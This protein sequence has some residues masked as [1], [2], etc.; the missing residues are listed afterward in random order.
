MTRKGT[1]WQEGQLLEPSQKGK[2]PRP[3]PANMALGQNMN[4][5]AHPRDPR[6]AGLAG[7]LAPCAPTTQAVAGVQPQGWGAERGQQVHPALGTQDSASGWSWW[8][9]H[10]GTELRVSVGG[11]TATGHRE[12]DGGHRLPP[13]SPCSHDMGSPNV[14]SASSWPVR[15]QGPGA[16]P[17]A[18][19]PGSP[20]ALGWSLC[21]SHP[22]R[23]SG[24]CHVGPES[25]TRR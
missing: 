15:G 11:T 6:P 14:A 5:K 17:P 19:P 25:R 23:G 18:P 13:P 9:S 16:Q 8:L 21:M 1:R 20:A 7:S 22:S 24:Q 4:P 3:G 10:S 12:E 2:W